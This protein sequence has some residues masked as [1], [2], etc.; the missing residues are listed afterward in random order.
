MN[1]LTILGWVLVTGLLVLATGC[2]GKNVT[3]SEFMGTYDRQG[4]TDAFVHVATGVDFKSYDKV[5]MDYLVLFMDKDAAYQ[6]VQADELNEIALAFHQRVMDRLSSDFSLV[7]RPG[8]GVLRIR[9]ALTNV[10]SLRPEPNSITTVF[11]GKQTVSVRKIPENPNLNLE[12]ASMEFEFLD[13][14]TQER[15]ALAVDPCHMVKTA[16]RLRWEVLTQTFEHLAGD[17]A[18][19]LGAL[20]AR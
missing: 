9:S 10:I 7:D 15:L 1:R 4:A 3:Y 12:K 19:K 2:A 14:L 17:L 13:S 16:G 18:G 11:P 8:P 20:K 6:G 5:M